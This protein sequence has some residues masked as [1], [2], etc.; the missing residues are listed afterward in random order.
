MSNTGTPNSLSPNSRSPMTLGDF[1]KTRKTNKAG[2]SP[3]SNG[4]RIL[5]RPETG[6]SC[7]PTI[8]NPR[9][10]F[11]KDFV[12]ENNI[13]FSVNDI[14]FEKVEG[15]MTSEMKWSENDVDFSLQQKQ[16]AYRHCLQN[17]FR[18]KPFNS[19]RLN[20]NCSHINFVFL[21][22]NKMNI[23]F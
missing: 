23:T 16:C 22:N 9:S 5:R 10:L 18:V 20:S 1:I 8:G 13:D 15:Q 2:S 17:D 14:V 12:H 7:R 3:D 11:H 19:F 21:D 6:G 4:V